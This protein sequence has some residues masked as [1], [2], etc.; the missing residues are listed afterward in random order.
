[1]DRITRG[2]PVDDEKMPANLRIDIGANHAAFIARE[3]K[4]FCNLRVQPCVV[5]GAGRSI[6][7]MCNV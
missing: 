1:M 6:E 4:A 5:N 7:C 2:T 3:E